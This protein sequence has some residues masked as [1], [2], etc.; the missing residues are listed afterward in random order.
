MKK[1]F[2]LIFALFVG[3]FVFS[4]C[5]ND[6][7]DSEESST[8][9]EKEEN[10]VDDFQ[11]K[12][13][14]KPY[15]V[16]DA[17]DN[18]SISFDTSRLCTISEKES[19]YYPEDGVKGVYLSAYGA[20]NPEIFPKI[21]DL[22]NDTALNTVVVDIKDDWGNVTFNFETDNEDIKYSMS[23]TLDP[24]E[25]IQKMHDNGI[26]VIGRIT[27]F[28][29]SVITE[30]HPEWAFK[31][32]DGTMWENANEEVFINPFLKEVWDYDISIAELGAKAGFD[33]IQFD[34]V[35]F[36]EGFE[37]FSENLTYSKG[38]F[39]NLDI[40]EGEKRVK[41]I[42]DFIVEAREALSR[43]NVPIGIDVFGY[44]MQ[45]GRAEGI[46]QD[47]AM[48][49]NETDVMSAMIYPSHWSDYS[50]DIEKPDFHPYELVES[51]LKEEKDIF[52]SIKNKPRSRPWIQDFTA[53]Y[54]GEGNYMVYD[55]DAVQAEINAIYDSG[56][57]EY[58]IWNALNEYTPG[59]EY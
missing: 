10:V 58:L 32:S 41:A 22:L 48:M 16:G 49:A 30:K 55:K 37:T 3:L 47:F 53:S 44:A 13:K 39:E 21:M 7:V 11:S 31:N 59:V 17:P 33:E 5:K 40:T 18:Y 38:E 29:D 35:R 26:Y 54:L 42:T 36:A 14:D 51:Y 1:V 52:N 24:K 28:K 8:T 4:S 34:Y 15:Y 46:G 45:V 12:P 2:V 57:N 27:T 43:Y 6:K 23:N 9:I 25:F 50:F 20:A 19:K 56:Q